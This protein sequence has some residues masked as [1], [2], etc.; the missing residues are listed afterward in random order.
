M[1]ASR[2]YS[3]RVTILLVD[4]PKTIYLDQKRAIRK[5]GR[6]SIS[7]QVVTHRQLPVI[8]IPSVTGI[9]EGSPVTRRNLRRSSA[10]RWTLAAFT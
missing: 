8:G 2:E 4:Y 9:G 6:T 10:A 7:I 1:A 5:S 3:P